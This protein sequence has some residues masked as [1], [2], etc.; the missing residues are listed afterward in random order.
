MP[1]WEFWWKLFCSLSGAMDE[2]SC[3]LAPWWLH[4]LLLGM[5]FVFQK[6]KLKR[7]CLFLLE[8]PTQRPLWHLRCP[9]HSSR[10]GARGALC[11]ALHPTATMRHFTF[12]SLRSQCQHFHHIWFQSRLGVSCHKQWPGTS[13]DL[14]T[15]FT[16]HWGPCQTLAAATPLK[17]PLAQDK[18]GYNLVINNG[19]NFH[20]LSITGETQRPRMTF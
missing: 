14:T 17:M 11:S 1:N 9:C 19:D 15:F 13:S 2:F 10:G 20:C 18:C 12:C 8:N 6:H 3:L 5:H 7:G 16:F 4:L